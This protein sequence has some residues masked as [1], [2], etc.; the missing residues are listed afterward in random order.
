MD[1]NRERGKGGDAIESERVDANRRKL[2]PKEL[3]LKMEEQ[4]TLQ[5]KY[6]ADKKRLYVEMRKYNN[7]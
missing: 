6:G 4:K 1:N 5:E 3:E 7:Y 2:S